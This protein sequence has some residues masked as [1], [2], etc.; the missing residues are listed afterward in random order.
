MEER[1]RAGELESAGPAVRAAEAEALREHAPAEAGE[2]SVFALVAPLSP[3]GDPAGVGGLLTVARR[4]RPFTSADREIFTSLAGQATI[5]LENINLH[6]LVRRQ[7][8]TDELTGL[9]NHRRFQE[10]LEAELERGARFGQEVGLLMLD[11]D[12]FKRVNDSFGHPQGDEVLRAV[13]R[14]LRDCSR[15]VDEPARYGGEEMA[16]ILP[17]DGHRGRVPGRRARPH[18]RWR[19]S[20]SPGWTGTAPSP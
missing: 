14:V 1:A 7:A 16:V 18:E 8:V 13:A 2:Q 9:S 19:R 4:D 11:V 12:D 20:A 10:T 15:D 17:A 6:E 3:P 5:S